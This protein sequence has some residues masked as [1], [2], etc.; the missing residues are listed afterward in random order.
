[1]SAVEEKIIGMLNE[2]KIEYEAVDHEPVYTNPA[3]AEALGVT[4]AQ[5]VR[6]A[7]F[8]GVK[9]AR[10]LTGKKPARGVRKKTFLEED[11]ARASRESCG[12][13]IDQFV[14]PLL[15]PRLIKDDHDHRRVIVDHQVF[16]AWETVPPPMEKTAC[17]AA[18]RQTLA[19]FVADNVHGGNVR[20]G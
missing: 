17:L 20:P 13:K 2:H 7:V 14:Q 19:D 18:G 3:M 5:T 8:A 15:C 10:K 11:R 16:V 9:F 6:K 4:E 12:E 1:M